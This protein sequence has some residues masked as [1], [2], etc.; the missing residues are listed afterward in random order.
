MNLHGLLKE[1]HSNITPRED[2]SISS[3]IV[4][5]ESTTNDGAILNIQIVSIYN[6]LPFS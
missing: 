3:C 6:T 5:F 4:S 2:P 1:I